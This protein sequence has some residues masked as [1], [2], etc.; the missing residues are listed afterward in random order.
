MPAAVASS[1]RYDRLQQLIA[2]SGD[3]RV[4]SAPY[5]EPPSPTL[6]VFDCLSAVFKDEGLTEARHSC[7]N[8][9][10]AKQTAC[11]IVT[12]GSWTMLGFSSII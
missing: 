1:A 5:V 8:L 9:P 7:E 4:H 10:D 12:N 6:A 11:L 3:E 2:I